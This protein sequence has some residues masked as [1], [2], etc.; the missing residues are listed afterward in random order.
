LRGA[1]LLLVYSLG[2]GL[3]FLLVG[4]GLR[5]LM[6]AL[7]FVRRNYHWIAGVSGVVMIAIGVLVATNLWTRMLGPVLR[8]ISNFNPPI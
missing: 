6:G 2:L 3:P 7:S 5:R 8:A 4:L 1:L